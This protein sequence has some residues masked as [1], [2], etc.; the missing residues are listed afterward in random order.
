MGPC[1]ERWA[2]M[3]SHP[4]DPD[5]DSPFSADPA[6]LVPPLFAG[7]P[8]DAVLPLWLAAELPPDA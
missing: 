6:V 8:P 3:Q 2:T 4:L 5:E 1:A 7:E